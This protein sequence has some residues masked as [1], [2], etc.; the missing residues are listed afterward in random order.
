MGGARG[1]GRPA[2]VS[3]GTDVLA[4][5]DHR[6]VS[7]DVTALVRDV[8]DPGASF[9][10]ASI[11]SSEAD[12]GL[13][14]GDLAKDIQQVELGAPDTRFLL[15]AESYSRAGRVYTIK[16]VARDASGNRQAR[17]LEVRVAS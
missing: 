10:L 3:L 5:A 12:S 11:G 16:C 9:V 14:P 6:L 2:E 4:P 15:R 7:I 1:F 17:V 8:V 13:G